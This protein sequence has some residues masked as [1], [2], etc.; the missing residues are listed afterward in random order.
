MRGLLIGTGV[1]AT[2]YAVYYFT[3]PTTKMGRV[4]STTVAHLKTDV[5]VRIVGTWPDG[6]AKLCTVEQRW[7]LGAPG[8]APNEVKVNTGCMDFYT[9]KDWPGPFQMFRPSIELTC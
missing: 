7:I 3:R 5:P 2:L 1:V 4:G 6:S 9:F 8:C